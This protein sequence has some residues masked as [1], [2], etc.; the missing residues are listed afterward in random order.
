MREYSV[1]GLISNHGTPIFLY[2]EFAYAKQKEYPT[3]FE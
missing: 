2:K 3:M 1:A